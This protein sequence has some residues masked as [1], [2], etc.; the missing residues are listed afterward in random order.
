MSQL[1]IKQRRIPEVPTSVKDPNE[2]L[3]LLREMRQALVDARGPTHT[4]GAPTNFKVTPLAGAILLQWSRGENADGTEIL[5]NTSPTLNG[6]LTVDV[7]GSSQYTDYVGAGGVKRFY[8]L[9]SYDSHAPA[10]SPSLSSVIGPLSTTS[11]ASGSGATPPAPPPQGVM[12]TNIRIG[13]PIDRY[14]RRAGTL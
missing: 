2:L 5:W 7:A 4:P 6:A 13:Y 10:G 14:G 12:S 11:L 3:D 8:W 1:S 9:A